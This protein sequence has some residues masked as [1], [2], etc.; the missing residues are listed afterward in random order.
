MMLIII[1]IASTKMDAI[2]I[3]WY[4]FTTPLELISNRIQIMIG[5]SKLVSA[6]QLGHQSQTISLK[7]LLSRQFRFLLSI[8]KLF[9]FDVLNI[10]MAETYFNYSNSSFLALLITS[11]TLYCI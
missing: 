7:F 5:A 6:S 2:L 8:L 9:G 1:K 4:L 10:E 3:T 11:F